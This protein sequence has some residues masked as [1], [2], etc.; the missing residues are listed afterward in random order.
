MNTIDKGLFMECVKAVRENEWSGR[1]A[2]VEPLKAYTSAI[3]TLTERFSKETLQSV[4]TWFLKI[5]KGVAYD[6]RTQEEYEQ[7]LSTNRQMS[8]NSESNK[9]PE[10]VYVKPSVEKEWRAFFFH[11]L[12]KWATIEDIEEFCKILTKEEDKLRMITYCKRNMPHLSLFDRKVD[13]PLEMLQKEQTGA[14][15]DDESLRNAYKKET[16]EGIQV[17]ERDTDDGLPF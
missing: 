13:F 6:T 7:K 17:E 1:K 8:V 16:L 11:K 12:E 4:H 14:P 5:G 10:K 3:N 2:G 15:M 9:A